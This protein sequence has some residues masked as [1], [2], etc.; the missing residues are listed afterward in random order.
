MKQATPK[1]STTES[2]QSDEHPTRGRTT[3]LP[4]EY[5]MLIDAAR[6]NPNRGVLRSKATANKA[7]V[8]LST[9]WRDVKLGLFAQPIRISNR[10]VA[11]VEV[12]V[13]AI[14]AAKTLMTRTA[15]NID[16]VHFITLLTAPSR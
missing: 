16:L 11:W 5:H 9:L 4:P 7:G 14:L 3:S 6:A 13:D 1:I 2:H 12:E 10:T 8:A 15:Q